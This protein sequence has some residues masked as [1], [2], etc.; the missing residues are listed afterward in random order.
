MRYKKYLF[1][2]IL[3]PSDFSGPGYRMP[4]A[5]LYQGKDPKLSYIYHLTVALSIYIPRYPAFLMERKVKN[6]VYKSRTGVYNRNRTKNIY[7]HI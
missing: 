1:F 7:I 5:A 3:S 2:S 4:V 6:R